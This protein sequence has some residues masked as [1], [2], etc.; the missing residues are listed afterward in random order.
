MKFI[1]QSK[2]LAYKLPNGNNLLLKPAG[3]L[4]LL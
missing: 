2:Q 4:I 1:V 3:N